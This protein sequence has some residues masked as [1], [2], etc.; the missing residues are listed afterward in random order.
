MSQLTID[1]END[2]NAIG[3]AQSSIKQKIVHPSTPL[4]ASLMYTPCT[5]RKLG[6]VSNTPTHSIGALKKNRQIKDADGFIKPSSPSFGLSSKPKISKAPKMIATVV[7]ERE[8][9][10]PLTYKQFEEESRPFC[11]VGLWEL[12][13]ETICSMTVD[14]MDNS[15]KENRIMTL[16]QLCDLY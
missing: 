11:T 12:D 4:K 6:N 14:D 8:Q 1:F 5:R 3:T 9:M 15:E 13:I 7:E 16:E 10:F 2:S